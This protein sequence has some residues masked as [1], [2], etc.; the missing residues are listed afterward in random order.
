MDV[1][2]DAQFDELARRLLDESTSPAG[3]LRLA[4]VDVR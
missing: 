1:S 3:E 4:E 2:P